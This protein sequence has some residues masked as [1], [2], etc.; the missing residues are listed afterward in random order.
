M[1][2]LNG[3]FT[4]GGHFGTIQVQ[5]D[6]GF[7]FFIPNPRW[8]KLKILRSHLQPLSR[9][10]FHSFFPHSI[11]KMTSYAPGTIFR[12]FNADKSAH[13]TAILLK[14]GRVLELK[15]ADGSPKKTHATYDAWV[16]ER[17]TDATIETDAS[18][19]SGVVF[20]SDTHG[21]HVDAALLTEYGTTQWPVWCY[22]IL[23][24][25]A[26][27]L[28][29]REDVKTVFN[30]LVE[31]IE[32]YKSEFSC[33]K[34]YANSKYSKVEFYDPAN[35]RYRADYPLKGM[36]GMFAWEWSPQNGWT[37]EMYAAAK[38]DIGAAYAALYELIS[39][40]VCPFLEKKHG[41]L[42]AKMKLKEELGFLN[43]FARR[44]RTIQFREYAA[45]ATYERHL[46]YIKMDMERAEKSLKERQDKVADLEAKV[47]KYSE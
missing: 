43:Y 21:F 6:R 40:D 34:Y 17:G 2:F 10:N 29:T 19:A 11:P 36:P 16:A 9:V 47:K 42:S 7:Q 41:L 31:T 44:V 39:A 26:P 3:T 28:L 46:R 33:G 32:K 20:T 22:R 25:C 1:E 12:S 35:L 13:N 18:K 15:N 8:K 37:A 27:K 30:K 38:A 24:E 4:C 5:T 23:A 45:K 14:D